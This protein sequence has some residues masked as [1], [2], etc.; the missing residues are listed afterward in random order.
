MP[1]RPLSPRD[2]VAVVAAASV[3]AAALAIVLLALIP[4]SSQLPDLG[5]I[6]AVVLVAMG[7]A[8][9]ALGAVVWLRRPDNRT[10]LLMLIEGLVILVTGLQISSNPWLFIIGSLTDALVISAFIHMLLAFPTGRLES[11]SSRIVVWVAYGAAILQIPVILFGSGPDLGCNA[12]HSCPHNPLLIAHHTTFT[13]VVESVQGIAL[14]GAALVTVFLLLRRYRASG[15]LAR[16]GLAPVLFV[17]AAILLLAIIQAVL[18]G[19]AAGPAAQGAFF[20]AFALLPV[21]FVLGLSRS[22]LLRGST[23][24]GL[25]DRLVRDPGAAGIDD[26]LAGVLS[27]PSLFVAYRLDDGAGYVDRSGRAVQLPAT[28][29]GE[30]QVATEVAHD[31]RVVAAVV[32]DAALCEEPELLRA[33]AGTA[34]L[35]IENAR[36]EAQLRARLAA[37]R[38]SRARLVE[39]GDAERRRLGRNL[40]DGAQQRLVSLML[41]LQ[42]AR[43]TWE[44]DPS[45][46]R[47]LVDQAFDNARAAVDELRDLAAGIHPAVLTQRG[48]DAGIES[49]ATRSTVPVELGDPLDER[50]PLP[51]ETAAYYVVAEALT[52]VAK[53]ADATHARVEV[54]RDNGELVVEVRDDG[55]GGADPTGGSGLRGLADRVGALDG[56]LEVESAA[57]KGTLVRAVIPVA[58]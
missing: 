40:H 11:R 57:G 41:E 58:G 18:R 48:L 19:T 2:R 10:G 45:M 51:V 52:N 54:R 42:I 7:V 4:G 5:W 27:D 55:A 34:A 35:A 32:H 16:R 15:P 21:A 17:G 49:L 9:F 33:A 47:G 36:L 6:F 44:R 13:N 31:G 25:V 43:E 38:A 20:I 37:L 53:Y 39:A 8:F 29:N 50:L 56:W 14:V 3:V 12:E 28:D 24:A 30:G 1:D 23:I 22:R 46:A 26:A